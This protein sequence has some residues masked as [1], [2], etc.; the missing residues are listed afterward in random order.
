MRSFISFV[1]DIYLRISR[2]SDKNYRKEIDKLIKKGEI[3]WVMPKKTSFHDVE[4]SFFE[5]MKVYY[6]NKQTDFRKVLFYIH[7]GY[8]LHQP[9]S[10]HIK[11]LERITK[12]S[13]VM[14]VFPIYPLAPFHT[15]E[16][17]FDK[18][19]ALFE[20]TQNEYADKKIILSGDSAGGGYSLA[21]AESLDKQPDELILLSPWVDITMSNPDIQKYRKIDPMLRYNKAVY[22]G[23]ARRGNVDQN[24][25]RVSPINGDLTKLKNVTI[26]MGTR[27]VFCP[28]LNLL[29]N[30]LKDN[31]VS[32][33]QLII[34]DKQAHV[35]PAFPSR[36]GKQGV[37]QIAEII[38]R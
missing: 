18:M 38:N 24:D 30:K 3:D 19:K 37:K 23:N 31:N 11:M 25:Y 15:V 32:N 21:L 7:G 9:L 29:F 6:I 2:P 28:D 33:I 16:E 17:S 36:E 35:Y 13:D 27:E 4:E 26:F 8:Y 14:I 22:A 12:Q 34:G 1:A 10:F 20:K 5:G